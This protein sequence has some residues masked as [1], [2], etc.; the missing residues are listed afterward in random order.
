MRIPFSLEM[1][2]N[3]LMLDF[4]SIDL[5]SRRL[6]DVANC[7]R[8][9]VSAREFDAL[10]GDQDFF[11]VLLAPLGSLV[12]AGVSLNLTA[13]MNTNTGFLAI[14][15]VASKC[16]DVMHLSTEFLG[17]SISRLPIAVATVRI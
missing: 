17:I 14:R 9:L 6:F 1:D 7:F 13:W 2:T 5:C 4:N 8:R 11:E 15:A 10:S 3:S 16:P 12:A